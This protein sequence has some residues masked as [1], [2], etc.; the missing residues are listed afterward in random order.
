MSSIMKMLTIKHFLFIF[1]V[2]LLPVFIATSISTD[3]A[4]CVF[5]PT[6][7]DHFLPHD[8]TFTVKMELKDE[9]GDR[10]IVE[11]D[12]D[13]FNTI[14]CIADT[15]PDDHEGCLVYIPE[16]LEKTVDE[17]GLLYCTYN[18]MPEDK[19]T[20]EVFYD[21]YLMKTYTVGLPSGE[22]N[23]TNS[24]GYINREL[25][26]DYIFH[27]YYSPRDHYNV[28]LDH[29]KIEGIRD[30]IQVEGD[31]TFMENFIPLLDKETV[32]TGM[33]CSS[34]PGDYDLKFYYMDDGQKI[35]YRNITITVNSP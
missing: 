22:W 18:N 28:P 14:Q 35:Y 21:D 1:I 23:F 17:N 32:V 33:L 30:M 5:T 11:E 2:L 20:I 12:D 29:V 10:I 31:V 34:I 7:E 15:P 9:F 8:Y 16:Y 24:P 13:I 27:Y 26:P 6:E 3:P 25:Y 4:E 19:T